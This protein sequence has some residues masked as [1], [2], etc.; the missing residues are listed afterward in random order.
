MKEYIQKIKLEK[1]VNWI[2][3]NVDPF[4]KSIYDIF[5]YSKLNEGDTIKSQY[6]KVIFRKGKFKGDLKILEGNNMYIIYVNKG[7]DL[8]IKGHKINKTKSIKLKKGEN[9]FS[10]NS[11]KKTMIKN[12][13]K[14]PLENDYIKYKNKKI[15]YKDDK[16][17]NDN[18]LKFFEPNKG[19]IIYSNSEQKFSLIENLIIPNKEAVEDEV[20]EDFSGKSNK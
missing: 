11:L 4:N 15:I 10:Y 19:Y 18:E 3:I 6:K 20:K 16:W 13:I 14:N 2:S 17:T 5:N 9:W 8:I 1:G 12:I 7:F